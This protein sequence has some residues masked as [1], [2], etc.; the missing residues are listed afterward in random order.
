MIR[1]HK[2]DNFTT[3]FPCKKFNRRKNYKKYYCPSIKK[4]IKKSGP[5]FSHLIN[6]VVYITLKY[7]EIINFK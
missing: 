2:F 1:D 4:K 3:K 5:Y 6:I 7:S